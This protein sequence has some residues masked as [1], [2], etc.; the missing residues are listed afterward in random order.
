[1]S[2]LWPDNEQD[3]GLN[4]GRLH[5]LVIGVADYPH[6][7]NGLGPPAKDPLLLSQVS[8]PRYTAERLAQWLRD[9]YKNS[10][11]PLGSVE[12]LVSTPGGHESE[13]AKM[14]NI[15]L[16]ANRWKKR[17]NSHPDNIAFFYFCGH[18]L[19]KN[20]QFLLPSDF[21]DPEF[22]NRWQNCIDF[23]G[24]RMGMRSC[25]ANTQ[26]FFV[27]ACRETPFGMLNDLN[28]QGDQLFSAEI[29]DQVETTATY[30]ATTTGKRAFGPED[31]PTYFCEALLNC[32]DGLGASMEYGEW[33]VDTCSLGTALG[34][35]IL[36]YST[37]KTGALSCSLEPSGI[38]RRLHEPGRCLVLALVSCWTP[39]AGK[40]AE[41]TVRQNGTEER[42]PVGE[43][44]PAQ[45]KLA[46][47]EWEIEAAFP[48]GQY[49]NPPPENHQLHP[50]VFKGRVQP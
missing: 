28:V 14:A 42:S 31:K 11:A 8:T 44:R 18:G 46:P 50:P 7:T 16:A 15:R 45:F 2:L 4:E 20:Q 5:A 38:P 22:D 35:T 9:E 10:E 26:L 19:H 12:W 49:P 47:G 32:F 36:Y 39:D 41:I 30:F 17:C 6:L 48:G 27:D 24:A 23:D 33:V 37:D 43:K 40:L 21:G 25:Q 29:S 34:K 13:E 3:I 1:M